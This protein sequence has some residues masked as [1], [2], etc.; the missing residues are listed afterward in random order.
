MGNVPGAIEGKMIVVQALEDVLDKLTR[1]CV[2]IMFSGK[3]E[4]KAR[5]EERGQAITEIALRIINELASYQNDIKADYLITAKIK[6]DFIAEDLEASYDVDRVQLAEYRAGS[7]TPSAVKAYEQIPERVKVKYQTYLKTPAS[8]IAPPGG[9]F[10]VAS[11][12]GGRAY[13]M[14]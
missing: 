5:C 1:S 8:V 12:I 9:I 2:F 6:K 13:R 4:Q 7:R 14:M 11:M 10:S 3:P